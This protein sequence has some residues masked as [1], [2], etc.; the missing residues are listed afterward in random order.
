MRIAY[1]TKTGYIYREVS[2]EVY[3]K[4]CNLCFYHVINCRKHQCI[5]FTF[6]AIDN[7]TKEDVC[8]RNSKV[9]L[10]EVCPK[11]MDLISIN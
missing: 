3:N 11:I 10:D 6:Y 1:K 7:D 2:A 9:T 4:F 5:E 8:I